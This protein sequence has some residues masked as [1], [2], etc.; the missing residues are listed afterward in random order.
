MGIAGGVKTM[1][2]GH[3]NHN[4][5]NRNKKA[6]KIVRWDDDKLVTDIFSIPRKK[7]DIVEKVDYIKK[8]ELHEEKEVEGAMKI[9]DQSKD[10]DKELYG[11]ADKNSKNETIEEDE[12]IYDP[13]K[14][15]PADNNSN[16]EADK[17]DNN[18]DISIAYLNINEEEDVDSSENNK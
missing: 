3:G 8:K 13:C 12:N 14:V 10:K 16:D 5:D 15:F 6:A 17:G 7:V 18:H 11:L 2:N 4:T 9:E 1:K